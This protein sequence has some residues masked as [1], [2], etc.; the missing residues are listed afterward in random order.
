MARALALLLGLVLL[1]QSARADIASTGTCAMLRTEEGDVLAGPACTLDF[2][3]SDFDISCSAGECDVTLGA[4]VTK[5]G[6]TLEENE[7][8]SSTVFSTVNGTTNTYTGTKTANDGPVWSFSNT[9][10]SSTNAIRK[11]S[12]KIA[13]TG[14]WG[15]GAGTND[16]NRCMWINATGG[17][18]NQALYIETGRIQIDSTDGMSLSANGILTLGATN[19]NNITLDANEIQ[20]RSNGS[21][22]GISI[23]PL[24]GDVFL[25]LIGSGK[26]AVQTA[27][28]STSGFDYAW[29]GNAARVWG[30]LRHGT[31]NTA[32]NSLTI[33]GGGAT[34]GATDKNAGGVVD[35]PGI[36]TGTGRSIARVLG[37]TQAT[38]TGTSDNTTYDARLTAVPKALTDGSAT[39][40]LNV[41]VANN[42][43]AGGQIKYFVE[44]YNGTDLQWE[45]GT[46]VYGVNN[47]AGTVAQNTITEANVQQ[48]LGSGTLSTTWAISAANPAVISL[49]ADSS[50]TPSTGYPRITF[51]VENLG[52][53]A[54]AEQ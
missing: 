31:A 34:S 25:N 26:L 23:N 41:T 49:N 38:A 18:D 13:C 40:L 1:A 51:T 29:G 3:G 8:P 52:R 46:V 9:A 10:T 33:R 39:N 45:S 21:A 35:D 54:V 28:S 36:P 6:S 48:G 44:V 42:T 14:S 17:T 5:L 43:A 32:G 19:T 15:D 4:A 24:G 12:Y 47:K 53:Q 11:D 2:L 22:A 37:Y 20:A 50:L 27:F 30:L 16:V 7:L